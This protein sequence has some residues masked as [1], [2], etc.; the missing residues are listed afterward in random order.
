MGVMHKI[1]LESTVQFFFRSIVER[2]TFVTLTDTKENRT[3]DATKKKRYSVSYVY[4]LFFLFHLS[5]FFPL[6]SDV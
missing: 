2:I 5:I 6:D 4:P 1:T 3:G